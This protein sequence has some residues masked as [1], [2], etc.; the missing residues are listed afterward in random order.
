[1]MSGRERKI[2]G[3]SNDLDF[4]RYIVARFGDHYTIEFL[5]VSKGPMELPPQ[6][7]GSVWIVDNL[8]PPNRYFDDVAERRGKVEGFDFLKEISANGQATDMQ[9]RSS[10]IYTTVHAKDYEMHSIIGT[11]GSGADFYNFSYIIAVDS[12]PS[13]FVLYQFCDVGFSGSRNS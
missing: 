12:Y 4:Q 7:E 6:R 3:V 11:V 8:C 2:L 5:P 1:M 10:V 13:I 9:F